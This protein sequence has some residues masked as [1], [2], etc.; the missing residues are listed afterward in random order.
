M[1]DFAVTTGKDT[2][3]PMKHIYPIKEEDLKKAPG[4]VLAEAAA[5]AKETAI[6]LDS[7]PD[8]D[9][10]IFKVLQAVCRVLACA[11]ATHAAVKCT[12]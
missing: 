8:P 12:P 4:S 2:K 5:I 7:W 10:S 6:E 11:A 1:P 9:H 3:W